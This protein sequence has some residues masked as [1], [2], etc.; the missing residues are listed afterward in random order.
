M[1]NRVIASFP[2]NDVAQTAL[3]HL[4]AQVPIQESHIYNRNEN[5]L[6]TNESLPFS[7]IVQPIYVGPINALMPNPEYMDQTIS[8]EVTAEIYPKD[9]HIKDA[10]KFLRNCGAYEV[11]IS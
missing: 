10:A 8:S 7:G 11:N 3:K 4:K 1:K 6:N 5:Q 2:D 9:G